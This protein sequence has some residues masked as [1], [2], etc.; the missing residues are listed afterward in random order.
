MIDMITELKNREIC[1]VV[2]KA[3]R[4]DKIVVWGCFYGKGG[5][6]FKRYFENIENAMKYYNSQLNKAIEKYVSK[7]KIIMA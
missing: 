7:C 4:S 1:I 3:E 5:K 6:D 2:E